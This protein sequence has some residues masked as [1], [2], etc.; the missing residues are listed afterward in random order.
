MVT[1]EQLDEYIKAYQEGHSLISDAEY[2]QLLEEYVKEHGESS[3]PF[4]RNQQSDSV[5]DVVGTLPKVYGVKV[6][7]RD[8][9]SIYTDWERK[10]CQSRKLVMVQPKLDG[11]S[12]AFDCQ[13]KRFFTRGDYDNGES[14]DVTELF[15]HFTDGLFQMLRDEHHPNAQSIKFE[16]IMPVELYEQHFMNKYKRP[17]DVVSAMITSR[18]TEIAK[19]VTLFPLRIYSNK[20]QYILRT[21][22]MNHCYFTWSD[23]FDGIQ[24]FIDKL[25]EDHAC[26]H[27]GDFS[28]EC[29]GVVVSCA[30]QVQ[31]IMEKSDNPMIDPRD[32]QMIKTFQTDPT[33][34]VA[35]K[36]LNNIEETHIRNIEWQFGRSGR[37]TPVAIVDPVKFGTITV[38]NIG[39]ST[40]ERVS[41][42]NLRYNDTVRVVYNIVP[43]L[44]D[45]RHDGDLPIPIPD[46]CPICGYKIDLHSMKQVRCTNPECRGRKLG[47]IIRYAEKMKMFGVS[48]GIL[49]KLFDM[50]LIYN[51]SDLYKL[52]RDQISAI[53]G[54]GYKS[55]ENI[56]NSIQSASTNVPATRFLGAIP[57]KDVSAKTWHTIVTSVYG[58]G[59]PE[60]SNDIHRLL[61]KPKPDEFLEKMLWYTN[62]IGTA[63]LANINEGIRNNWNTIYDLMEY[64]SFKRPSVRSGIVCLTGTRDKRVIQILEQHHFQ[65]TDS[66]S[67]HCNALIIPHDG[68]ES[69][70]TNMA[71]I[72]HIPMY[73]VDDVLTGKFPK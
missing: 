48:E 44:L 31:A 4:T 70:K 6:P 14:E 20:Q 53:E 42:M 9:Q 37:I 66:M 46:K 17:R 29:D 62:G 28:Y 59:N 12:I 71:V 34:E 27:S 5:N 40:F 57:C 32:V 49:T 36:I 65:V 8:N 35:I 15:E 72:N 2:D 21:F 10:R 3:R 67:K 24:T 38:T 16:A 13:T 22:M 58:E 69:K 61:H 45:S 64:V 30:Q 33:K 7:M 63:T 51:I 1:K 39:L 47:A 19:I 18:N 56:I 50:G 68:F 41:S 52:T 26:I 25:L 55:A 73:T 11:C 43:Y 60:S 54:F 23:N